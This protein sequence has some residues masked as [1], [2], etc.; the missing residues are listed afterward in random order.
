MSDSRP[1]VMRAAVFQ[2]P[3]KVTVEERAVPTPG[4]GDV[5]LEV[6]HCGVCGSDVH[7]ALDGWVRPGT[8]GGHEWSGRVISVGDAVTEWSVGDLA[9]GGPS[10]KC[11]ECEFCR[12]GRSGLCTRRNAI[13]EG[14]EADGAF[15]EYVLQPAAELLRPPPGVSA[16][17]AALTEPLAVSLHALTRADARAGNR[18]LVTGCGPIGALAVAAA[19]ARGV[20]DVVVSEPAPA[21]RALAERLGAIAVTPDALVSPR[22]PNHLVDEPFDAALECSGKAAATE[23]ALAQLGRAGILVLVGAGMEQPRLDPNRILLNEL[24]V[25]GAFTYDDGG[26]EAALELLASGEFPAAELVEPDDVPLDE[27]LPVVTRL[28]A[29]EI[30]GKVLISPGVRP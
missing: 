18:L 15:A 17:H 5:L 16:R 26:F 6:S 19:H 7:F 20:T 4:S 1:K 2:G 21:R 12:S 23:A 9:V 27:L 13:G 8:V 3:G 10:V 30:A 11:G 29:G 25:T 28:S 24:V 22:S 14:D